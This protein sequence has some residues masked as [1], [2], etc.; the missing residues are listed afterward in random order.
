MLEVIKKP[1]IYRLFK[2]F[3][4]NR[5]KTNMAIVFNCRPLPDILIDWDHR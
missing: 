1:I 2:D 4:R 5:K 3:T